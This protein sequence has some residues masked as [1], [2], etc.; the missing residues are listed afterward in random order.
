MEKNEDKLQLQK[1]GS[2][3]KTLRR[4]ANLTV[5][6]IAEKYGI[7]PKSI[8]NWESGVTEIGIL[9]LVKYLE[10]FADHG[11]KISID[12]LLDMNNSIKIFI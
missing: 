11:I 12:A 3:L 9:N 8:S 6:Y 7:S 4:N 5:K 10:V 2:R 1:I